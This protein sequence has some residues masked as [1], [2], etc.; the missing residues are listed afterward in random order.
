MCAARRPTASVEACM[1]SRHEWQ[2]PDDAP[3]VPPSERLLPAIDFDRYVPTIVARL[4]GRL[5]A[6][7]NRFFSER[8][9]LSLLEWRVL[10]HVAAVKQC[11]AYDIWTSQDLEKAAVSRTIRN[12][13]ARGLLSVGLVPEAPRRTTSIR[14]TEQG[15]DRYAATFEE[16]E[17]RHARLLTGLSD[18]QVRSLI[19]LINRLNVQIALMGDEGLSPDPA[20]H[21]IR[22]DG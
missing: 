22:R 7:S 13:R 21:S 16:A 1:G 11:S 3:P 18:K 19:Q 5:R 2:M 10:A 17:R 4:S 12:L 15:A 8:F 14:L 9:G 20:H 6:S